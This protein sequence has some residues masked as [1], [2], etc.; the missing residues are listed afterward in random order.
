MSCGIAYGGWS[1]DSR[2]GLR[3]G[4]VKLLSSLRTVRF[5]RSLPVGGAECSVRETVGGVSE[6]VE[7]GRQE[8]SG[9]YPMQ[10]VVCLACDY[11]NAVNRAGGGV[12]GKGWSLCEESFG[13]NAGY[14]SW[15]FSPIR[16]HRLH[17]LRLFL[18]RHKRGMHGFYPSASSR[19]LVRNGRMARPM[20]YDSID[21]NSIRLGV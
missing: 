14:S 3:T 9:R 6:R 20:N 11:S 4:D 21:R 18:V 5:A 13:F 15:S 1:L 17:R 12:R 2:F 10:R 7:L 16:S 8:R 19:R